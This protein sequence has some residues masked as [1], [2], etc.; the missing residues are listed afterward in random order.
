MYINF[1]Q[2]LPMWQFLGADGGT[3]PAPFKVCRRRDSNSH[4]FLHWVLN[5]ARLPVPPLRQKGVGF[6]FHHVRINILSF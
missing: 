5:P 3:R 2:K 4:G 6:Q 1:K